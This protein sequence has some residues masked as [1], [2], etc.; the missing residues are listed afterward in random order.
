MD[1][2]VAAD[3]YLFRTQIANDQGET[4]IKSL[5]ELNEDLPEFSELPKISVLATN[6][7][8]T[9]HPSEKS[10]SKR[11]SRKPMSAESLQSNN[12]FRPIR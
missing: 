3:Q 11:I 2:E 6:P 12:E 7:A 4:E 9:N 1:G 10:T 8:K 5:P